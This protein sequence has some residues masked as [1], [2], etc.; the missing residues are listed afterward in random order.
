[1]LESSSWGHS[2]L[3]T[4][5]LVFIIIQSHTFVAE[6]CAIDNILKKNGK[7]CVE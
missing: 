4:P 3:Q 7:Y 1:M 5:V 2:V 6:N